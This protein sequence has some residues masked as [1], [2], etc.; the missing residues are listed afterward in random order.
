MM[1]RQLTDR[2]ARAFA[3]RWTARTLREI[4]PR[5]FLDAFTNHDIAVADKAHRALLRLARQLD[6]RA[7]SMGAMESATRS[8]DM[9]PPGV[10]D[11]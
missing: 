7:D 9:L 8:P 2:E 5:D 4:E 10:M 11:E 1:A 3:L 6:A